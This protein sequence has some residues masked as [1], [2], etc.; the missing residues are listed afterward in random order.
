GVSKVYGDTIGGE[1]RALDR[2]SLDI[3]RGE[4]V[5]IIG[6][7]GCGKTTLLNNVAGFEAPSSGEVVT[8]R[9]PVTGPGPDRVVMFQE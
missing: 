8:A 6:P 1:V 9:G 5:C 4:F 2:V 3:A 7:S